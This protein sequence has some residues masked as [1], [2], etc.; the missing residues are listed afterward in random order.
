MEDCKFKEMK[1]H[2]SE[3]RNEGGKRYRADAY[4]EALAEGKFD[5]RI[6]I[7]TKSAGAVIGKGGEYI[8][9]LRSNFDAY[10]TVP[11]RST[12]ERVLSILCSQDKIVDCFTEI[13]HKL[14]EGGDVE[15]RV[16]VHQSHAGA[17]IGRGG[18]KIKELREQTNS[19]I[20]VFQ[21]CCPGSTDR[22]VLISSSQENIPNV[23]KTL[24]DFM[25]EVPLKGPQKPYDAGSYEPRTARDYG[26]YEDSRF[27]R[28]DS[29]R[30]GPGAGRDREQFERYPP[31][32]YGPPPFDYGRGPPG[33]GYARGPPPSFSGAGVGG[34]GGNPTQ[35]TQVTI[36]NELG[37]TIIGKGGERINRIRRES[38]AR[39]EVGNAYGNEER[40]ITITGTLDQI[41]QAQYLLQQSVRTSEAGRR[42]LQE[43]R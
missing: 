21:E 22:V 33:G 40:I 13:L 19:A 43:Q 27:Q 36:P 3:T 20:K 1:R 37:G 32:D 24:I 4:N 6:L 28:M 2:N 14:A 41:Q 16:L 26:G 9:T 42:Y 25:I 8:K 29:M 34:Y 30:A 17:I 5:L 31:A 7:P 39:I 12:P 23:V 38:G 15:I 10:L 18:A 35:S 11:D